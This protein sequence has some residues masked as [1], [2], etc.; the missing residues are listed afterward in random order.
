MSAGALGLAMR[1]RL[2]ACL[3]RHRGFVV[4]HRALLMAIGSATLIPVYLAMVYT[5]V[6]LWLVIAFMG[7]AFS[8]IPAVMWPSV[9]YLVP[10]GRLG[11]AYA[12]MTLVQQVGLAGMNWLIGA[13]NDAAQASAANPAGYKPG[14]WI[15]TTLGFVGL[16]FSWLLYR[17]EKGPSGHG[18]ETVK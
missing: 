4:G 15:F 7:I 5:S 11:T 6:P 17:S 3:A 9:A 2:L 18:L 8:L 12:L 14:M 16:L 13:T 10:E 1:R